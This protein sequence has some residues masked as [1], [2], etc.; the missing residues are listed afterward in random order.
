[1]PHPDERLVRPRL[2]EWFVVLGGSEATKGDEWAALRQTHL[3]TAY[4]LGREI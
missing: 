1:M 4:E 3:N 2:D